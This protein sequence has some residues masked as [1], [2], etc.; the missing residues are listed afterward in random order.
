MTR[1]RRSSRLLWLLLA[2]ALF[3]RALVPQGYMAERDDAGAITVKVCGSGHVLQIPIGKDDTPDP[4][5]RA[6]PPCAF[7]GSGAPALPPPAVTELPL[8]P[9]VESDYG[10]AASDA[11]RVVARLSHPPARGPPLSA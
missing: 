11:P 5:E 8:R 9:V 2:A 1:A 3:M 4:D 7:A 6:Q 10:R